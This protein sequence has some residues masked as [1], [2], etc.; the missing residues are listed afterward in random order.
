MISPRRLPIATRVVG[1]VVSALAVG[2]GAQPPGIAAHTDPP[3]VELEDPIEAILAPGGQRVTIGGQS[4]DFWWVKSLPLLSDTV[5]VSWAA[6]EEGTVVGAVKLSAPYPDARG[7]T[8]RSGL[9]TLRYGVEPQNADHPGVSPSRD[10]LLLSPAAADSKTAALGHDGVVALA[11]RTPG[12]SHPPS[13]RLDPPDVTRAASVG[14]ARM[15]VPGAALRNEAGQT[16][17]I[18]SVPA[19]REGRDAGVLTFGLILAGTLQP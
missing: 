14:P 11:K 7:K 9:Y 8:I 5:G 17:V 10:F 19:S 6:V 18:F 1:I 2:A 4:L 12:M 15:A 16:A 13:W 3:P